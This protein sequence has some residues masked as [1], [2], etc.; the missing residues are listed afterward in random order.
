MGALTAPARGADA[1]MTA[2]CGTDLRM[3]LPAPWRSGKTLLA[4]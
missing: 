2:L 4:T 3:E 1:Q